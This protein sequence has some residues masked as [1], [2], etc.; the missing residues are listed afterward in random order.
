MS[1]NRT[2]KTRLLS[3]TP[4]SK[5]VLSVCV[6]ILT[7]ET[8]TSFLLGDLLRHILTLTVATL[9][10]GCATDNRQQA[11]IPPLPIPGDTTR[12]TAALN[13]LARA[14][15]TSAPASAF[16]KRAELFLQAGRAQEALTD[17]DEAILRRPTVGTYYLTRAAVLRAL[18]Q[19]AKALDNARRAEISGVETPELYTILGD[20]SQQQR[21]YD[22]ARL[23][24]AR[25]LQ[26]APFD[27]E[28]YFFEGLIAARQ[29]DTTRAIAFY[30]QSLKLKPR[31]LPTYN[32]MASVY[33]SLGN[34]AAALAY[35]SR[36]TDYFPANVE[37]IYNRGL[38]YHAAARLDSALIC[39]RQTAK[40]QPSFYPAYF[41]AG[42]VF[43]KWKGYYQALTNF[44]K[45]QVLKPDYP[46]IDTYI[47]FCFEKTGQYEAAVAA[48][49]KATEGNPRDGDAQ[50]SLYRVQRRLTWQRNGYGNPTDY[51]PEPTRTETGP[52]RRTGPILDTARVRV[53]TIQPRTRLP[54]R[55]DSLPR[56]LKPLN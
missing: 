29:G 12:T 21:Q 18:N 52:V 1:E 27:G 9:L 56:T 37:L 4:V 22:K 26:M 11:R 2:D 25:A 50:A 40:Q 7:V 47:G 31:Y 24:L 34:T 44:Q 23:Y 49:T 28:A 8:L 35:N 17:I 54:T 15:R 20:L 53:L 45:V 10:L 43:Q 33:R 30:Q 6:V 13:A 46:D 42:L 51:L 32:Q 38:I 55:G 39:Y 3:E 19:P 36:A 48:Y 41:Q 16:A 5:R 14:I